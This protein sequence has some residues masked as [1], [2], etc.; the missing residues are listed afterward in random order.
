M[1][2]AVRAPSTV[3]AAAR[4]ATQATSAG[5]RIDGIV[6]GSQSGEEARAAAELDEPAGH[7]E[8]ILAELGETDRTM[9]KQAA[10]VD[11][12]G[13]QLMIESA[14]VTELRRGLACE[15]SAAGPSLRH[16]AI[17]AP[18]ASREYEAEI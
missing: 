8:R 7:Y 12:A 16:Q 1:A 17:A 4:A 15:S 14:R 11:R 10:A 9:L 6:I 18:T 13:E 2:E 3:L 5:L